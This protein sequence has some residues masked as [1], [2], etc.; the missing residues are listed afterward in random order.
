[1]NVAWIA[2]MS[3][4]RCQVCITLTAM[5]I[6]AS[7]IKVF[8]VCVDYSSLVKLKFRLRLA[9]C[10]Q[11]SDIKHSREFYS[12]TGLNCKE[13]GLKIGE[14]DK[15]RNEGLWRFPMWASLYQ[16]S[17]VRVFLSNTLS[18]GSVF[19]AAYSCFI[20]MFLCFK[21]INESEGQCYISKINRRL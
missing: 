14:K 20:V 6:K 5:N 7:V 12:S 8:F 2:W 18:Q 1:M 15:V 13:W 11:R 10:G 21:R 9:D 3:S 17:S 4:L 19:P 16:T